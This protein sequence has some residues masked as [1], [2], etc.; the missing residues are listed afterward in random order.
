[1]ASTGVR[2]SE[3]SLAGGRLGRRFHRGLPSRPQSAEWIA[4]GVAA[5][6]LGLVTAR[7]ASS[8]SSNI[9]LLLL[10]ALIPFVLMVASDVRRLLLLV[11]VFDTAFQWDKNFDYND[12]AAQLGAMGGLSASVTTIALFGLYLMW[13]AELMTR[14][15][16]VPRS[17]FRASLPLGVYLAITALSTIVAGNRTLALFEV[18]L[19]LQTFLVFFYV[20]GTVQTREDVRFLVT[21]IVACL[22]LESLVTLTLPIVGGHKIIG[23]ST[24][25]ST[26]GN[27][28][29]GTDTRFGGT[30]GSPNTAAA[31]FSLLVAPTVA[32]TVLAVSRRLKLLAAAAFGLATLA[33]ILTLSRGGWI[34]FA[35]SLTFLIVIGLQRGWISPR[36]P[37]VV[38]IGLIVIVLPF[39]GRLATRLTGNDN[40]SAA[41]RVPLIHLAS[42]VIRDHPV[43][44][45]GANQLAIVFPKYAGPQYDRAWIYTVHNKYLL[46]WAEAGTGALV[47]FL[48]FLFSTLRRGWRVWRREDAFLSVLA[49]GFT[50]GILGQM[51]HMS[52]DVF[53]SRPQVQALWLVAG[54]L[55]AMENVANRDERSQPGLR[56]AE[57][58]LTG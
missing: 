11:V 17:I 15:A 45:V 33:L 47:A 32:L 41:S 58:E 16:S 30:I 46:V 28:A 21:A 34:A 5:L 48:W 13:F 22:F 37:I 26:S 50:A 43:L 53:A 31:F 57:Q 39:S 19:F 6:I 1:M 10:A 29:I 18:A 49:L 52:V 3:P 44:G 25:A 14:R 12:S 51:V 36:I 20:A 56:A 35:V 7:V 4:V 9:V 40:G 42:N 38:A 27:S 2:R 54:L 8:R 24:Y 55:V 23:V